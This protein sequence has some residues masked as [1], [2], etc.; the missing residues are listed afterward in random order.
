MTGWL[1]YFLSTLSKVFTQAKE[2]ALRHASGEH[3]TLEPEALR[4]LDARARTVLGLFTRTEEITSSD[5]ARI[6][7]LSDRAARDLLRSWVG[8]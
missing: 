7:G 6:L 8:G 2:E 3:P 1:E 5:V 4:R